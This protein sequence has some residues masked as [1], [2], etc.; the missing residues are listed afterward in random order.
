MDQS[1]FNDLE[2]DSLKTC[3]P[4]LTEVAT[5]RVIIIESDNPHIGKVALIYIGMADISSCISVVEKGQ[6]VKKGDEIGRF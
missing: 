3:Q 2:I 1:Q 4:F 5:R 6:K